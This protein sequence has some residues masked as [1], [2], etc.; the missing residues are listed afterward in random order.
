MPLIRGQHAFDN[1]FTQ[2][3]NEWL[4]DSRLT[5]KARGLLSLV[6]SHT[7]GWSLSVNS[8]AAQNKEGRDS[9]RS[10]ILELEQCGY[11]RRSQANSQGRF[12]DTTWTTLDPADLPLTENPTT[13]NPT[14]VNPTP[15]KNNL[16]EEQ[17]K[18]EQS[19]ESL[20]TSFDDF[21]DQYPLKTDKARARK[22]FERSLSKAGLEEILAGTAAYRDDLNRIDQFTK[23][24]ATWLNAE[25]WNNGP[26]PY[27]P[28]AEKL[29][30]A[31]EQEQ[32]KKEWGNL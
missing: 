14:T 3:P 26:L 23:Y 28:R 8:L 9:I 29:R 20:R 18:E 22:A 27:D 24:P 30:N 4:R 21:W 5:F 10:A 1:H 15:K 2:V 7:Q 31:T 25:A 13:E 19:K 11:L 17:F 6:M 16:K 32:I 12:G